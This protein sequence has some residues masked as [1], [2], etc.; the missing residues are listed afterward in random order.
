MSLMPSLLLTYSVL[1]HL[2]D[3]EMLLVY[4]ADSDLTHKKTIKMW[5]NHRHFP[6]RLMAPPFRPVTRA[7]QKIQRQTHIGLTEAAKTKI[8]VSFLLAKCTKRI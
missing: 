3:R 1:L 2:P 4:I 8:L 7:N 6:H 5:C